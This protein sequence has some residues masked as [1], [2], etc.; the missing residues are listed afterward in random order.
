MTTFRAYVH[1]NLN[2]MFFVDLKSQPVVQLSMNSSLIDKL[3]PKIKSHYLLLIAFIIDV[4]GFVNTSNVWA[5]RSKTG[6]YFQFI[7]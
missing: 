6:L 3:L 2:I 5:Y 4:Y 7:Y 1:L